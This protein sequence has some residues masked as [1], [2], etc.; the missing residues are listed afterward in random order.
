MALIGRFASAA[1]DA[2]LA[3]LHLVGNLGFLLY[4]MR[5]MSEGI[6]KSAGEKMQRALSFMTGNRFVAMLTGLAITMIIQSSGATS[7]MVISFVN[8]QLITLRQAVGVIF[9]ANIG[10]TVTAWIVAL[11]GFNFKI[12]SI[13]VPLVGVGFFLTACK[14]LKA[15]NFGEAVMG[16]GLVFLGL[17]MMSKTFTLQDAG[18]MNFILHSRLFQDGGVL[19]IAVGVVAGTLIT[20]L[21]HSSSALTAI[22]ITMA[23]NRILTWDFSCAMVIGSE[24]GS[25]IDAVLASFGAKV[26]ARRVAYVHVFINVTASML[27]LVFFRPLLAAVDAIVPGPV[28]ANITY[29]IAMMHTLFKVIMVAIF[30]PFTGQLARL[31]EH[32]VRQREDEELKEYK[33]TIMGKENAAALIIRAEKE[34]AFLTEVVTKMFDRIQKGLMKRD[35]FVETQ[36]DLLEKEEDFADQMHYEL[37]RFLLYA[38]RLPVTERQLSS[39]SIM[40]QVVDE[41]EL[42]TDDCL[43]I[44][45]LLKRSIDKKMKFLQ[46]DMDRLIPYVELARQ[47]LQFIHININ[48]RLDE[49]KIAMASELEGQ[50]DLFRKNLKKTARK[51]LESGADVKA[52][53]LYI[54]IVR[55]IE[56]IGDRAFSISSLLSQTA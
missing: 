17:A 35:G 34:I 22:V 5:L 52:E 7:V 38:Q 39:I 12:E 9:G 45:L 23:F 21:I 49:N 53:L 55:Q 27:A 10:T 1:P 51:R 54:D 30:L 11:F 37:C 25:T 24:M 20:A 28:E 56:K 46:E 44:G 15:Q 42:M 43:N 32:V 19:S 6:Q 18:K 50:I 33:L 2:L 16:F 14:R 8:A 36:I 13:A 4:G 41:L 26:D 3:L 31:S 40:M 29:H 48:R 47:F